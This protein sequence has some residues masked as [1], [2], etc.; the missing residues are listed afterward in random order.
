MPPDAHTVSRAAAD[1]RAGPSLLPV[2]ILGHFAIDWAPTAV[3]LVVPAIAVA[4]NLSPAEV[5]LMFTIHSAG[6]ALAF[7]PAGT[8]A[9]RVANRGRLLLL[10]FWW[11]AAGYAVASFAPGY[12]S[13]A[14]LLAFAGLGDAAWHPI[15]TGVLVQQTPQRRAQSLGAHAI[16]GSLAAVLAPL[17]IGF[18]LEYVDWRGALLISALP[19]TVMGLVFLRVAKHVPPPAQGSMSWADAHALWRSWLRPGGLA[20]I[21]MIGAYSM[22]MMALL[23][24]TPLFLQTVHGVTTAATGIAFSLML[25][26]GALLQPA[27]GKFSDRVGWRPIFTGG[28]LIV[29]AAALGI[30]LAP[31]PVAAVSAMVV[32]ATALVGIRSV[33]L[34]AAVEYSGRREAT[35]L[36]FTFAVMDGVGALGAVTAGALGNVDLRYAFFLVAGLSAFAVVMAFVARLAK[37]GEE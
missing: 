11:V 28:N 19:A 15:A 27:V 8:L 37:T 31:G 22:A 1:R 30:A 24:M 6:A 21:V 5:G 17:S 13:I 23:A 29:V 34:A 14:L 3:W 2:F 33:V 20:L 4:M 32:T 26:F 7:L 12:W 18:L 36:G 10:T 16:G 35:T 9:D 25:L